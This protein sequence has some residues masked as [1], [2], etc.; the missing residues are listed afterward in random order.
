MKTSFFLWGI[1]SSHLYV[2]DR[3]SWNNGINSYW[4]WWPSAS[5]WKYGELTTPYSQLTIESH[6]MAAFRMWLIDFFRNYWNIFSSDPTETNP[7]IIRYHDFFSGCF[8]RHMLLVNLGMAVLF[9]KL[10]VFLFKKHLKVPSHRI[11]GNGLFTSIS[12]WTCPLF[13]EIMYR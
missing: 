1:N 11:H 5:T 10:V 2:I 13:T 7:N 6:R 3:K 12:H 9:E 4:G 8:R